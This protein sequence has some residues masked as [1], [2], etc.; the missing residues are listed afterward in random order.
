M[1]IDFDRVKKS[2]GR[3]MITRE[4]KEKF[5]TQFYQLFLNS[6]PEI[7]P[8]FENTVFDKQ[9]TML[10]NAIGMSILYADKQDELAKDVLTK[11]RNSHS[12]RRLNVKPE[13]YDYWLESLI[14]TLQ[15]CDPQFNKELES[16]WRDMMQVTIDYIIEGY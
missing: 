11:I 13:Y 7:G 3:C 6:H 9:I 1:A 14:S 5:F 8:M 2:Y 10:K 15:S 12:S 16:D 4:A